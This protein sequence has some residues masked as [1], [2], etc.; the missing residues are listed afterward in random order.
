MHCRIW[1]LLEF[2]NVLVKKSF[3]LKE[4]LWWFCLVMVKVINKFLNGLTKELFFSLQII[5]VCVIFSW[6]NLILNGRVQW[7]ITGFLF[8]S[9]SIC[10]NEKLCIAHP[11]QTLILLN[12]NNVDGFFSLK[13][14]PSANLVFSF[15]KIKCF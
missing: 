3:I 15:F 7:N 14:N 9:P 13:N 2:W 6:S 8:F 4:D 1:L 12:F 10:G 5:G 11:V